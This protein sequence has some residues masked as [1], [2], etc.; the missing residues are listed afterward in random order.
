M[1]RVGA[2]VTERRMRRSFIAAAGGPARAELIGRDECNIAG[3][4]GQ[5]PI[6]DRPGG[7]PARRKTGSP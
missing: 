7:D 5:E 4:L 6:G 2:L 1:P 3:I